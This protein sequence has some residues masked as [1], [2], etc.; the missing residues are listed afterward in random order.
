MPKFLLTL[1]TL[2]VA[3]A[4]LSA[5]AP[6]QPKIAQGVV[7]HNTA[8]QKH[9]M[10]SDLVDCENATDCTAQLRALNGG[11]RP[12]VTIQMPRGCALTEAKVQSE[13]EDRPLPFISGYANPIIL[14]VTKDDLLALTERGSVIEARFEQCD[15]FTDGPA[16]RTRRIALPRGQVFEIADRLVVIDLD[17]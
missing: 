11:S 1:A 14:P 3:P 12:H 4:I 17:T 6:F 8:P 2:T 10:T 5:C 7:I 9:T 13:A 16:D 15:T